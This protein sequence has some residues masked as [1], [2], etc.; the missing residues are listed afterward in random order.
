M[1]KIELGCVDLYTNTL[2]DVSEEL[3]KQAYEEMISVFK[4]KL[5]TEIKEDDGYPHSINIESL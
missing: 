3:E 2:E 5:I 4:N 1:E